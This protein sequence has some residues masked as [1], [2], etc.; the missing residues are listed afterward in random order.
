MSGLSSSWITV[1]AAAEATGRSVR[2]VRRWI[3]QSGLRHVDL[4][5][6]RYV[7]EL[8]LLR[9]ERDM[10]VAAAASRPGRPGP[11]LPSALPLADIVTYRHLKL[12]HRA[13]DAG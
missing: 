6:T 9:L 1:P 10:R 12:E 5:G 11:R 2:T 8:D 7:N 4:N 13:P 3:T